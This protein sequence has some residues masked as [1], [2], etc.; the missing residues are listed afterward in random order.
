MSFLTSTSTEFLLLT[1]HVDHL[2]TSFDWI[3][4]GIG[5]SVS[6]AIVLVGILQSFY[7]SRITKKEIE[8]LK[9]ELRDTIDKNLSLKNK[10][11]TADIEEK[12]RTGTDKIQAYVDNQWSTLESEIEDHRRILEFESSRALAIMS[13]RDGL[14]SKSCSFW[15]NAA[16]HCGHDES[17]RANCIN[18]AIKQVESASESDYEFF[19]ND[20]SDIQKEIEKLKPS[21]A[22]EMEIIS[23]KLL[24]IIDGIKKGEDD[25]D[26]PKLPPAGK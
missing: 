12:I 22:M 5:V 15:L 23:R 10:E 19:R 25:K 9:N 4:G 7:S 24:K 13:N 20:I 6:V 18:S 8:N 14:Y 26:I 11:L 3:V 16:N 21:H 17:M 2:T 1:Q